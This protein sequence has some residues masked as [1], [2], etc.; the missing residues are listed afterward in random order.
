MQAAI[1]DKFKEVAEAFDVLSDEA[2]RAVYDK[3]RDFKVTWRHR[4]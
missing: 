4:P 1:A 2:Q 3:V